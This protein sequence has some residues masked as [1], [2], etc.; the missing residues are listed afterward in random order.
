MKTTILLAAPALLALSA[1][2]DA[3]EADAPVEPAAE[4]TADAAMVAPVDGSED[5]LVPGTEYNATTIL[6][7]GTDGAGP[8]ESC[9]AGVIRQ[10][11]DDGTTLVEVTKPDGTKRA[12]FFTG[13]QATGAD[14]AEADGSAGWDFEVTRE[15]DTST[16][17]FGPESYVV[18]D[19]LI[20]GG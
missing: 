1:C 9:E 19:A 18:V 2:G 8:T 13:T 7:C 12:I 14:S 10:W 16:I 3:T 11:G 15:G 6:S 20:E 17:T 4:E 5:A